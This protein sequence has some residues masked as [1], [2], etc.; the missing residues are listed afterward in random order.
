MDARRDLLAV[1]KDKSLGWYRRSISLLMNEGLVSN[2]CKDSLVM[3][4]AIHY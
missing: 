1:L 4:G 3:N 2:Q